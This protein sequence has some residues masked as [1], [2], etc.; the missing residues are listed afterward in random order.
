MTTLTLTANTIAALRNRRNRGESWKTL[1]AEVGVPWQKLWSVLNPERGVRVAL[2]V[3]LSAGE[4]LG[5]RADR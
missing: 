5:G 2:A 1:A 3:G 4:P